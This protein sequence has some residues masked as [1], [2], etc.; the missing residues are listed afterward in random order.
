[1]DLERIESVKSGGIAALAGASVSAVGLVLDAELH[2]IL[3][4]TIPTNG[5]LGIVPIAMGTVCAFLFGVTYRYIVRQDKNPHLRSGAVGAF[6]L[7]RGLSQLE[8]SNWSALSLDI[9]TVFPFIWP[10]VKSFGLFLVIR[11]V[12]DYAL[13]QR[14]IQDFRAGPYPD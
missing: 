12:L 7:T 6:A 11:I 13:G 10:I 9:S 5:T 14:W 3:G 2:D 4:A 8:S 1:M